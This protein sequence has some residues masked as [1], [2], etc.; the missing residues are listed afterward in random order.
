V[1]IADPGRS[2]HQFLADAKPSSQRAAR[3]RPCKTPG[4]K[5]TLQ[6]NRRAPEVW[7]GRLD[8]QR[9]GLFKAM[10]PPAE[11]SKRNS[12]A[13][14]RVVLPGRVLVTLGVPRNGRMNRV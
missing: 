13:H 6:I 11:R 5:R 10:P 12:S 8:S 4:S 7:V 14:R 9:V 1:R 2:A 3:E